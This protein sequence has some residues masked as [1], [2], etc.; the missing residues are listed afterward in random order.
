M[1]FAEAIA[2]NEHI[3]SGGSAGSLVQRQQKQY[4]I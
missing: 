1:K 2:G 3:R 4:R